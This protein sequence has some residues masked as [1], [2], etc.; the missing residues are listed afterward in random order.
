[1]AQR[2]D[3]GLFNCFYSFFV[4]IKDDVNA[5]QFRHEKKDRLVDL[6]ELLTYHLVLRGKLFFSPFIVKRQGDSCEMVSKILLSFLPLWRNHAHAVVHGAVF[7]EERVVAG[8][9]VCFI[10][11]HEDRFKPNTLFADIGLRGLLGALANVADGCEIDLVEAILVALLDNTIVVEVKG[12]LRRLITQKGFGVVIVLGILQQLEDE[13]GLASV[14]AFGEAR[15]TAL[16]QQM[17]RYS[18]GATNETTEAPM[19]ISLL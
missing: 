6:L 11:H 10:G 14:E 8:L 5:L 15:G 12:D 18:W 13:S 19:S 7:E 3:Y 4:V 1:M 17:E 9:Y 16:A 2:I